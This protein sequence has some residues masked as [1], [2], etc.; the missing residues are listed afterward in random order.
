MDFARILVLVALI[1]QDLVAL[2]AQ[3]L[4]IRVAAQM[5]TIC[6]T[7]YGVQHIGHAKKLIIEVGVVTDKLLDTNKF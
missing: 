2:V 1:A 5:M 6:L 4:M 3:A 7:N